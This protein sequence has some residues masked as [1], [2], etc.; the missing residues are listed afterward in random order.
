MSGLRGWLK[1]DYQAE[2]DRGDPRA[3]VGI[4][5][6]IEQA[7]LEATS[8]HLAQIRRVLT[9]LDTAAVVHMGHRRIKRYRPTGGV[10]WLRSYRGGVAVGADDSVSPTPEGVVDVYP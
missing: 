2:W 4:T 5:N 6:K 8:P 3:R 7:R 1:A 10:G 9:L